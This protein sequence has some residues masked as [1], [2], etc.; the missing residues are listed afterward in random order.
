MKL[1]ELDRVAARCS[2]F[3]RDVHATALPSRAVSPSP[4]AAML[5]MSG[6]FGLIAANRLDTAQKPM[7]G[8]EQGDTKLFAGSQAHGGKRF[9]SEFPFPSGRRLQGRLGICVADGKNVGCG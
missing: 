6:K 4:L 2:L 5:S 1:P 8:P 9:A 7:A 3:G